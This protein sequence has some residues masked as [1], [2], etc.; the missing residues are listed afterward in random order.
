M[1]NGQAIPVASSSRRR[2]D[3]SRN[4]NSPQRRKVH[5]K[6]TKKS[7]LNLFSTLR[8]SWIFVPLWWNRLISAEG[9]Q[10]YLDGE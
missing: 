1:I 5:T 3:E 4:Q 7:I 9:C 2:Y 8:I 10:E 6:D